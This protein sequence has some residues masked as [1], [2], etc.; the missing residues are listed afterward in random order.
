MVFNVLRSSPK[1]WHAKNRDVFEINF[2]DND[3]WIWSK[4]CDA[5]SSSSLA[6]L[7]CCLSEDSLKHG[8]LDIY[9]TTSSKSV[10]SSAANVL[11]RSQKIWHV[12]K[13][14]VFQLNWLGS[15][16]SIWR[17]CCDADFSSALARLPCC[18][19]TGSLKWYFLGIYLTTFSES[20]T[21]KM[22]NLWANLLG[23]NVQ[24]FMQISKLQQ[25]IDKTFFV[26]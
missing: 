14:N 16:Q 19:P 1:I 15:D 13:R 7:P 3:Q 12:L 10:T 8:F 25:E 2:L 6:R 24:N 21:S 9:L 22:E 20:V 18:F 4:Y 26:P 17:R 11:T 23:L 5:D